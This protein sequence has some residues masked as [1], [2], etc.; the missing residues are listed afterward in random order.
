MDSAA[1]SLV[2]SLDPEKY[3]FTLVFL[4][5]AA[6]TVFYCFIREWK[7]WHL[8]KDMPTARLRSAHQG[9]IELEGKG[10]SVAD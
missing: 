9:Y 10:R 8:I 6:L 4:I 3:G 7:R 2:R 5:V 1:I